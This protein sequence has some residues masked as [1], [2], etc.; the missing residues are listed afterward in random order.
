MAKTRGAAGPGAGLAAR[1]HSKENLATGP[2]AVN[3]VFKAK[4]NAAA[5]GA[6]KK[7]SKSNA[8]VAVENLTQQTRGL[9]LELKSGNKENILGSRKSSR[10]TVVSKKTK[11]KAKASLEEEDPLLVSA[12]LLP[13][14]VDDIDEEEDPQVVSDNVKHIYAYL[15]QM[16]DKF[17]I[18][19][20]FL[21]NSSITPRMRSILINWLA[22]VSLQ[23]KLLPETLYLTV[24]IIDRF[25]SHQ[26]Q[27]QYKSLQLVGVSSMLIACKYEEM[28]VPEVN[29]FVFIT[30]QAYD[31][32]T[33]LSKELEILKALSFN[34]GKPIALNFLRRNSKAGYV[35]VRHHTL[36]KYILEES[37]TNY[38]LAS[39]KPS[40]KAAAALL[41][42]LKIL[43][44][45]VELHELW[46]PN[47][48]FY[49]G[50]ALADLTVAASALSKCLL[51]AP[52]SKYTAAYDKYNCASK[53]HV[54]RLPELH[55][56]ILK[57]FAIE[58]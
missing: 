56:D 35:G 12:D 50:Y 1:K 37:L 15:R 53:S 32:K 45:T 34:I 3:R 8:L 22:Q 33:I 57:S 4:A 44:P 25:L 40:E 14:G 41:I 36:A 39:V 17:A 2:G 21:R 31:T 30:D 42:S 23:F 16:E 52:N 20:D 11:P 38:T 13:P 24:E 51:Q 48:T 43:D 58:S 18:P 55:E 9:R 29:D 47:L 54:S 6:V 7:T 5:A 27:L 28:Y 10:V 26:G 49:S 46:S 19:K